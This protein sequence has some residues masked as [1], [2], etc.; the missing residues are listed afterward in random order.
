[1]LSILSRQERENLRQSEIAREG[2]AITIDFRNTWPVC[3][4][5]Q[6]NRFEKFMTMAAFAIDI[7]D[8]IEIKTSIREQYSRRGGGFRGLHGNIYGT[9][10]CSIHNLSDEIAMFIAQL[11]ERFDWKKVC[12]DLRLEN[13]A[14]Q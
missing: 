5:S 9:R 8:R 12:I 7:T 2:K 14:T 3:L 13:Q 6:G 4:L 10:L 11:P 1:M